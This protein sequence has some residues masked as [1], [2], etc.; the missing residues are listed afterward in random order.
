MLDENT[1]GHGEFAVVPSEINKWNWGAFWLTWIW[2]IFNKSYIALLVF[3]PIANIIVPFYLG[4]R[5]SELAW[6]NTYWSNVEEFKRAQRKW[7]ISAWIV[8]LIFSLIIGA[9]F[10]ENK[11]VDTIKTNLT[12]EIFQTV[13]GNEEAWKLIGNNYTIFNEPM[14]GSV[15]MSNKKIPTDITIIVNG[16]NELIMIYAP[17][18]ENYNIKEIRVS[19]FDNNKKEDIIINVNH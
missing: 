1:S 18:D 2:G 11:K 13:K 12:N 7:A 15:E 4:A 9:Q 14:L 8:V 5:G 10:I 3:L 6:K 17:L 16:V 19:P